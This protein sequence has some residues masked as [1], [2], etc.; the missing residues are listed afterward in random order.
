MGH[1]VHPIGF[2][3]GYIKGWDSNWFSNKKN[4][5]SKLIEDHNIRKYVFARMPNSGIAR[6]VVER[7]IKKITL[8]IYTSKPGFIIGKG[9]GGVD[10]LKKELK[11]MYDEDVYVNIFEIK[12]PELNAKLVGEFIAQQLRARVSYKRVM[13]QSIA[14]SIRAGAQGVK[15]RLSG[16]LGG[17]EIARSE[18]YRE[19][20]VPLHTLRAD[21][22]YALVEAQTIYGKIGVKVWIFTGEV[23]GKRDLSPNIDLIA[24]KTK[25]VGFNS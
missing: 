10:S 21:I 13:K 3:L 18:E 14:S 23:Y 9:G 7:T 4:Y 5:S 25:R 17:A 15:I 20:R 19:G 12:R 2:R 11:K 24:A 16:R 8:T 1:K 22:D 6:V